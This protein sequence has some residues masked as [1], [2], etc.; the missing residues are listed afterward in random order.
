MSFTF[1]FT[2]DKLEAIIGRNPYLDQWYEAL[3]QILPDYDI[4]TPERVAAF[5]AKCAHESG[6]FRAIK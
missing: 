4:N 5:V 2:E 3:C 6:G 1:D